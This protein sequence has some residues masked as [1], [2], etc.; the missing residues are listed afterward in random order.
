MR[1]DTAT[2]VDTGR[3]TLRDVIANRRWQRVD[4][5][6]PHVVADHVFTEP[7]YRVFE[8]A[9]TER[10]GD[11]S[12]DMPD[13]DALGYAITSAETGPL[14]L[15][16]SREWHD[17][18][19]RVM[20][21]DA[22]GDINLALHHHEVRSANG[23]IHNDL[24]PGW[25]VAEDRPDGITVADSSRCGYWHG[26]NA[27]GPAYE[28][29]R[30]VALLIYVGNEPWQPGDGGETGLYLSAT[31]SVD[32]PSVRVPPRNNS[33]MAFECTPTSYHS[34]ISNRR[35]GRT[36]LIQWLHRSRDDVVARWGGD[37]IVGW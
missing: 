18:I 6:F 14:S 2:L 26:A 1:T 23:S 29:I 3:W 7:F 5:P 35:T 21:V 36:S 27:V 19:A 8:E 24:N 32:E 31:Q 34:F 17:L 13:Y 10:L 12:R 15:F 11:F 33:L 37:R 28:R 22:T 25:F 30:A 16:H 4:Y 20:R 9:V